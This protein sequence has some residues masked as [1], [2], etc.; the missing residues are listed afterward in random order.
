[1]SYVFNLGQFFSSIAHKNASHIAIKTL[2]SE[3]FSFIELEKASNRVA[4]YIIGEGIKKGD[5]IAIL[6]NK[7]FT[8]YALMLACLKVGV[9]YTNLDPKSPVERFKKMIDVCRPKWVF[10]SVADGHAIVNE[11]QTGSIQN[12]GYL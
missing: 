4:N 10:Y 6:N 11:V 7:T 5:V 1:M 9:V 3:Y 8:A 2:N 12:T